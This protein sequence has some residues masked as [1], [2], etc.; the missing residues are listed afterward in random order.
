MNTQRL[1]LPRQ[2]LLNGTLSLLFLLALSVSF[3]LTPDA[4]QAQGTSIPCAVSPDEI[5]GQGGLTVGRLGGLTVGRLGLTPGALGLTP[6]ALGLTPGALGDSADSTI[7]LLVQEIQNNPANA[8]WLLRFIPAIS[9]GEGFNTTPVAILIVDD[10][11][12]SFTP[13]REHGEL[14]QQVFADLILGAGL[15]QVQ[16]FQV[17]VTAGA[18]F[19]VNG[20]NGIAARIQQKVEQLRG[21]GYSRFVVNLSLGLIPCDDVITVNGQT[22]N[23]SINQYIAA[24]NAAYQAQPIDLIVECVAQNADSTFTAH[25]GFINRNDFPVTIPRGNQNRLSG[26]GLNDAQRDARVP[27]YF[28]IPSDN[29]ARPSGSNF[30]PNSAFQITFRNGTLNWHFQGRTYRAHSNH[31]QTPRCPNPSSNNGGYSAQQGSHNRRPVRPV[32]ECV[33]YDASRNRYLAH[34]GYEN[35]N[36]QPVIILHGNNNKLTGGG[37]NATQLEARTPVLFGRANV[38]PNRPGRTQFFPNSAFTIEFNGSNLVWTLKGPDGQAR[39]ATASSNPAQRCPTIPQVND[40]SLA[41]FLF[42][43]FGTNWEQALQ[44]LLNNPEFDD[45][46]LNDLIPLLQGYLNESAGESNFALIP[47]ASSGNTAPVLGTYP[48]APARFPQTIA[49]AASLG[50]REPD[51]PVAAYSHF[52]NVLAPGAW[53]NFGNELY[54][55]GTSYAAPFAG[56][57]ASAFL[58][59]AD[60]D[61]CNF[62]GENG[63]G[64]VPLVNPNVLDFNNARFNSLNSTWPLDCAPPTPNE[65]PVAGD[66]SGLTTTYRAPITISVLANDT[67]PDEDTLFIESVSDPANGQAVIVNEGTSI[68]YTPDENFPGVGQVADETFTY[69][70]SDGEETA[71]ATV[72]VSVA[73]LQLTS[74]C[75]RGAFRVTNPAA[76]P[77]SF[78]W[79]VFNTELVGSGTVEANSQ[80]TFNAGAVTGT[81]RL[82]VDSVQHDVKGIINNCPPDA[83]D[84]TATTTANSAVDIMVLTNDTDP[85]GNSLSI[86]SATDPANGSV[87]VLAGGKVKYTPA[88]N[89]VGTDSFTYT[90]TDGQN[91]NEGQDTATVNI[92]VNTPAPVTVCAARGATSVVS[93]VAGGNRDNGPI[94]TN[95]TDATKALG[96]PQFNDSSGAPINFVSLGFDNPSTE[97]LEGVLVLYFDQ[98]IFPNAF[99]PDITIAETTFGN[100]TFN[101]YPEKADIYASQD[102]ETW[103]LVGEARLETS[104]DLPSGL[105]WAQYIKIVNTT[106]R[107]R[108]GGNARDV[109]GYDV[110]GVGACVTGP[111]P[112]L[113][114]AQP[115]VSAIIVNQPPSADAGADQML[116]D[117][118]GDSY[119][120]VT[121]T[122]FG[123]DTDGS[124]IGVAWFDANA[125]QIGSEATLVL[126]LPV[127]QHVLTFGVMDNGGLTAGDQVIITVYPNTAPSANFGGLTEIEVVDIDS[128]GAEA[129]TLTPVV[130]DV[131]G[132]IVSY[133]WTTDTGVVIEAL[134]APTVEL[135]QGVHVVTLVVT[136]N[137]G[138]QATVTLVVRVVAPPAPPAG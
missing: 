76:F 41:D 12:D 133:A 15:T 7:A 63:S 126:N 22:V 93:Y 30:Y 49:V 79:D 2:W 51:A 136:D 46:N 128:S 102:N 117:S 100:L 50:Q 72:T 65:P 106:D 115:P 82:F 8:Q 94:Q 101:Q 91:P 54:G 124:I 137:G 14:V 88:L 60:P 122:G 110:D 18:N 47:F 99:G 35:E 118:N 16:L 36:N 90:I 107:T 81:V 134:P 71:T 1:F 13:F 62:V 26:G 53:F 98:A 92:T 48:L 130:A 34:F 77:I 120:T 17:D 89:Y 97:T 27:I 95:R 105:S 33:S 52:G 69:T 24:R 84:D 125:V 85:D 28:G 112:A 83:V 57:F 75:P 3:V 25:F 4:A 80:A 31:R 61:A 5:A 103:V 32:L 111:A 9:A 29:P 67:D 6:G 119:E 104:F 78:I 20:P 96:I 45:P 74:L 37:L 108:F 40:Y 109:D 132:V 113:V 129:V 42:S 123:A 44:Q 86:V 58:T 43:R 135:A 138:A 38:I 55:A 64:R 87:E 11:E 121:V 68:T 59:Y 39:T 73:R 10:F 56:A 70:I 116:V 66:D 127:G 21:Q 114:E 19:V 23:W 131:D